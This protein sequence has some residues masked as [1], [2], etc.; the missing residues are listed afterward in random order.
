VVQVIGSRYREDLCDPNVFRVEFSEFGY[1]FRVVFSGGPEDGATTTRLLLDL[2]SL[3]KRPELRNPRRS[4][5]SA[6]VT[7]AAALAVRHRRH[8]GVRPGTRYRHPCVHHPCMRNA[9]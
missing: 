2:F 3:R 9:A 6:A 5:N 7:G 4:A 8:L 1:S